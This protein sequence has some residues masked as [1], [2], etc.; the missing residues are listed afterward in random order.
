MARRKIEDHSPQKRGHAPC[1]WCI[2]GDHA[3][4][5]KTYIYSDCS[6]SCNGP[7]K[8]SKA[9]KAAAVVPVRAASSMTP[10]RP[11]K[12]LIPRKGG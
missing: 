12:P 6:C 5:R 7:A 9:P 11:K 3:D 1:G 4:C 2:T 10:T 8:A